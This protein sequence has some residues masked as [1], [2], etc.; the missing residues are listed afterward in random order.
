MERPSIFLSYSAPL[1][2]RFWTYLAGVL[3]GTA[4]D[5]L[6]EIEPFVAPLLCCGLALQL[7]GEIWWRR[8]HHPAQDGPYAFYT[9]ERAVQKAQ[10]G[11]AMSTGRARP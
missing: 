3:L 5:L 2:V 10:R 1:R 8:T 7:A 4:L 9:R 6:L 11:G